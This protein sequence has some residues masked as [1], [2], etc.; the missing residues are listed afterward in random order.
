MNAHRRDLPMPDADAV[1]PPSRLGRLGMV[2]LVLG[3]LAFAAG[4]M[5]RL[6]D[7]ARVR[8]EARDLAVPTVTVVSPQPAKAAPPLALSGEMKPLVEAPIFSRVPGYVKKWSVDLGAK[9]E[10]GQALAELDTP[11][12]GQDLVK[13]K[14]ELAQAE[15]AEKL[16][17]MTAHRWQE[18]LVAKTVSPQETDEKLADL[19]LKKATIDAARANVQRLEEWFGYSRITAPFAGTITSRNLDIGQLVSIDAKEPLFTLAQLDKL[20]V[21]VRVPQGLA[22]AATIGQTAEL[23]VPEL[24][25]K[26]FDAK[27]V[28]N[29]GAFDAASRTLLTELEVDNTRGELLA[30][31]FAQVRLTSTQA[32]A[33]LAVPANTLL[34]RTEGAFVAAVGADNHIALRRVELGRDFGPEIEL[35]GG[36]SASDRLVLNPADSLV[37]GMEVRLA[38]TAA[39]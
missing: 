31:G 35:L 1:V 2:A 32:E 28:R 33:P 6:K 10:A 8:S 26:K 13:S 38:E 19:K 27:I 5:P 7:R 12:M 16:A 30:G 25:G 18:M 29:A 24:A 14:A 23:T 15:A 11:E 17:E 20:R 34:F 39:K 4:L 22:R 37:D 36:V 21:F 9:V 3:A